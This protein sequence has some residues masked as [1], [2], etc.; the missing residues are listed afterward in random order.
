ML[1]RTLAPTVLAVLL[2]GLAGCAG[3][4]S[5]STEPPRS[6]DEVNRVLDGRDVRIAFADGT[7]LPGQR[8]TVTADSV[9]F[10]TD[11]SFESVAVDEVTQITYERDRFSPAQGA[12]GG[13]VFGIGL[14]TLCVVTEEWDALCLAV[15]GLF[16]MGAAIVGA[17]LSLL[18]RVGDQERVAY[19]GPVARYKV[20]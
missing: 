20:R 12:V 7:I 13:A 19:E 18:E 14:T 15:G 6:L 9:H 5:V 1:R 3:S 16:T 2:I 4:R 17:G 10:L 11:T 8:T